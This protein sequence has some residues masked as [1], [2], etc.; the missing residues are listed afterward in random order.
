MG[1]GGL[2]GSDLTPYRSTPDKLEFRKNTVSGHEPVGTIVEVGPN[3][4]NVQV[5]QRVMIHHYSG[6]Q[7]CVHCLSGWTQLC[8]NGRKVYGTHADG[9]NAEYELVEDYMCVPMPDG[10]GFPEAAA[11][12]CGTGTA[13]QALKRLDVSGRDVLAV[14]GQG[15]VGLS[16][17]F[18]GAHMGARVIGIDPVPERRKLAEKNGAWKTIDPN[19]VDPVSAVYDLTGGEGADCSLDATGIDPVRANAVRST[20]IWGRACFVGEGG[21]VSLEPTPDI[22]H[23]QLDLRGSWTFSTHVLAECARWVVDRGLP[24]G[25]IITH[26]FELPQAKEAFELFDSGKTGKVV[27]TF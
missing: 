8:P 4:R 23:R 11:I 19:D 13:Y 17:T 5:G 15:P 14:Y 10:L 2:C 12:S 27:F 3:T 20:R 9:S 18:F 1:A 21:T 7:K 25:D 22:I 24:L 16:A 26:K 6:C